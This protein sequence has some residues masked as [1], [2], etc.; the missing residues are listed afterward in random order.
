MKINKANQ[1][2]ILLVVL[3]AIIYILCQVGE[4]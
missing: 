1:K 4:F 3:S 2:D